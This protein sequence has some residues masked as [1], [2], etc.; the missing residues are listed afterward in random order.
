[1]LPTT[2]QWIADLSPHSASYALTLI[3]HHLSFVSIPLRGF[4]VQLVITSLSRSEGPRFEPGW[5]HFCA[6]FPLDI[7]PLSPLSFFYSFLLFPSSLLII[8]TFLFSLLKK[9]RREVSINRP[10]SYE[11]AALPLRHPALHLLFSSFLLYL[12]FLLLKKRLHRRESNPG[13]KRE[14]LVCY[15]LH[16]NGQLLFY[17][18][19]LLLYFYFFLSLYISIYVSLYISL[20]VSD[21]I[22]FYV[23]TLLS[24]F[25][26]SFCF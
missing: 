5:N 8:L 18:S 13:H 24:L 6:L 11:P 21:Y 23:P 7:P 15:Q 2:P 20:Y 17:Y 14:R 16:H 19:F 12:F 3:Y 9:Q 25:S 26:F 1:M 22:P 4:M 10:A